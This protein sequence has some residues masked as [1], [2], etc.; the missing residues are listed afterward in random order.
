MK[1][2]GIAV[3][4]GIAFFAIG[5]G[6]GLKVNGGDSDEPGRTIESRYRSEQ[7]ALNRIAMESTPGAGI[8]ENMSAAERQFRLTQYTFSKLKQFESGLAR[9]KT[10]DDFAK[11]SSEMAKP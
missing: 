3:V 5:I 4:V 11:L 6:V 10:T 7:R 1:P 9:A 2:V 8:T